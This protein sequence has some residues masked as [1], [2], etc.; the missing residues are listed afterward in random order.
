MRG[1]KKLSEQISPHLP[2]ANAEVIWAVMHEMA[3]SIEDVLA[4]R[5]RI[6]LLDAKAAI[7]AAPHVAHLMDRELKKSKAW[8]AQQVREFLTVAKNYLP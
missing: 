3:R 7:D 1:K 4:R 8:E 6:L 5:T 2:Y